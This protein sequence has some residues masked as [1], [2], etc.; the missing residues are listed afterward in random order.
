MDVRLFLDREMSDGELHPFADGLVAVYSTRSPDKQTANEDA[1][2]LI[3]FNDHAG[4]LAVADGLGGGRAGEQASRMALCELAAS[5]EQADHDEASLRMAIL[6]GI[7]NA[8]RAVAA[9]GLGAGT[10]LAVAEIRGRTVRSY[11]VGDSMMLVVGQRGKIKLQTIC[12]S[13]VGYA[14]ESGLLDESE[15]MHHEDR[16]VVSNMVGAADMRIELGSSIELAWHDTLLLASDGLFDNLRIPEIVG[17]VRK[18][19]LGKV[20]GRLAAA[21][22]RRMQGLEPGEPNKPDDLT[23]LAFRLAAPRRASAVRDVA[24]CYVGVG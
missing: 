13:P 5:V 4:V 24:D 23:F 20:S 1:A 8:N 12:H 9:L 6:N 15:A 10:T 17:C 19:Q 16:H 11:H 18:G 7:E 14:V 3:P 21:C 22:H 2:V